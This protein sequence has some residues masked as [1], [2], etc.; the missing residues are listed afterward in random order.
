MYALVDLHLCRH[1]NCV[2]SS[3]CQ[4]QL[5][6]ELCMCGGLE[7]GF[8]VVLDSASAWVFSAAQSSWLPLIHSE[9]KWI[10][11]QVWI[12]V[13]RLWAWLVLSLIQ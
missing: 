9:F 3:V 2:F 10:D 12:H 5:F 1:G 6:V 13:S 11:A 4:E 8:I 7:S